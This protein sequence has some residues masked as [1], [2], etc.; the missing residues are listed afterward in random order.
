MK[1]TLTALDMQYNSLQCA[2]VDL[3]QRT[4]ETDF[5]EQLQRVQNLIQRLKHLLN[6]FLRRT[7]DSQTKYAYYTEQIVHYRQLLEQAE[8]RLEPLVEQFD[9]W[10]NIDHCLT[11]DTIDS[12][13][14]RLLTL[15]D[16]QTMIQQQA[17]IANEQTEMLVEFVDNA[18]FIRYDNSCC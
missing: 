16:S 4:Q 7:I 10:T 1:I 13:S 18:S 9:L 14:K 3:S 2:A 11:M 17:T 6:D 5:F 8:C 15:M 12:M